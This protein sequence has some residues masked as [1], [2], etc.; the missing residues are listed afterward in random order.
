MSTQTYRR[1]LVPLSADGITF[2]HLDLIA[3]AAAECGELIVAIMNNDLKK[4]GYLFPL[5]ERLAMAERAI[6]EAGIGNVRVLIDGGLL[7]DLYMREDCDAVFRGVRDETDRLFEERQ[8]SVHAS[9]HPPIAGRFVFLDAKPELDQVSSSLVKAF[10]LHHLDISGLV[11]AFVK[12]S[13]EERL[14]RQYKVAV[15]GGIAVGKSSVAKG[16]AER[17]AL[18]TGR[19]A[20][21]IDVDQLVRDLYAEPTPGAQ[22]LREAIA[23]KFGDEVLTIDRRDVNRAALAERIFSPECDPRLRLEMQDLTGPHVD[24][25]FREALTGKEGLIVIE[26]AQLAEMA[27]GRWANHRVIV[28]DSPDRARFAEMRGIA[29]ERLEAIRATQ[30]SAD[31]KVERLHAGATK[32]NDGAILRYANRLRGDE[33]ERLSD[34]DG[35]A[36]EVAKLFPDFATKEDVDAHRTV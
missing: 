10:V 6:G 16:L 18:K 4:G 33:A 25:K 15:T 8:A 1:G 9:I 28:V 13:L 24:R 11:P 30:W 32:A 35:L 17:F 26:W 23:A 7:T 31:K 12:R 36:A 21:H 27:L 34:L 2:G 5:E 20:W 14:V 3:R 29:P 22:A 19:K